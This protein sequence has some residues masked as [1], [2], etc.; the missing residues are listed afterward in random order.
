MPIFDDNSL[1]TFDISGTPYG[2]S[3]TRIADL[4]ASEYTLVVIA[5]DTSGSVARYAN[6]I[7]QCIKSIVMSCRKAPRV[8]NLMLRFVTFDTKLHESHGF[9]PLGECQPGTY[10]N[11]I[12]PGGCTA[13]FDAAI[14]AIESAQRYGKTLIDSGFDVNLITFVITDGQDNSSTATAQGVGDT[15]LAALTSETVESMLSVLIGVG[16]GSNDF[17]A[18]LDSFQKVAGFDQYVE[19]SGADE[20]TLAR[21]ADFVGQSI[22]AQ[23]RALGT[24]GASM[25]LSF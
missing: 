9:R 20:A 4:G 8:D 23:S 1:S 16:V 11:T 24:G 5:A 15:M 21:L 17:S 2:F 22:V 18:Y 12:Q 14:N 25:P 6:D 19:L 7:E 13:L 3:A 10:D